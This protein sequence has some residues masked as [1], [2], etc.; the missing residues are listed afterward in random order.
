MAGFPPPEGGSRFSFALVQNTT[1]AETSTYKLVMH[2][3][4]AGMEVSLHRRMLVYCLQESAIDRCILSA[5]HLA[6]L[7]DSRCPFAPSQAAFRISGVAIISLI[8][9]L[10][11]FFG[12]SRSCPNPVLFLNV[13]TFCATL[14]LFSP[15]PQGAKEKVNYCGT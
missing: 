8:R 5:L 4:P 7:E 12:V 1:L 13:P 9:L 6:H 3:A 2:P 15:S 10:F 11:P 14:V